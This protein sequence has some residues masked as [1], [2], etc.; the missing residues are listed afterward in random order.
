VRV[1]E[2]DTAVHGFLPDLPGL[3]EEMGKQ[4]SLSKLRNT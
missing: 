2:A 3:Q 1:Q 4:L